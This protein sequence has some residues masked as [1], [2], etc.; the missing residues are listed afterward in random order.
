MIARVLGC[1]VLAWGLV[2]ARA[3]ASALPAT[4]AAPPPFPLVTATLF[5]SEF[6]APGVVRGDYRLLTSSGPLHVTVVAADLHDPA[7]RLDAVTADDRMISPGETI[8]SMAAR[9]GAVAGINADYFD[10][11]QT[12]QPTNIVV[13]GGALLHPPNGRAAVS[14]MNDGSVRF[15][16][17]VAV[18]GGLTDPQLAGVATALGGGPLL[19]A[20]GQ[21]A[22]DPNA[23]APEEAGLRFPVAGIASETDGTLLLIAVDG[24]LPRFSIGLTRAELGALMLALGASDGMATDS[25]GSATLV[26]RI[27]GERVPRVLNTPSDGK[28]RPVADGLFIYSSAPNGPAAHLIYRPSAIRALGGVTIRLQGAFT[29][30]A[31]HPLPD[32]AP[33]WTLTTPLQ[34]GDT[35]AENDAGGLV[36]RVPVQV[37]SQL[38]ALD[39]EPARPNPEPGAPIAFSATGSVRGLIPVTLGDRVRWSASTGTID[40]SGNFRA[41]AHDAIVT[42]SAGGVTASVGVR[43]GRHPVEVPLFAGAAAERWRFVTIPA[44]GPGALTPE[45]DCRCLRL[46]YDFTAT[47]R[48]AY[49]AQDV[50]LP[51][52]AVGF[53]FDVFGDARGAGLRAT[54]V[55]RDGRTF[56]V[57]LA[58]RVDWSG[59]RRIDARIPAEAIPPVRLVSIYAVGTLGDAPVHAA[60]ALAFRDASLLIAGTP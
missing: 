34:P 40:A 53:A 19:I 47:E 7:V 57:T 24:R 42:A 27:L 52:A 6:V 18:P 37:V 43:V 45:P 46:R 39:V 54:L 36:A 16:R 13:R 4:I 41:G 59:W 21:P 26:A 20:N 28:E 2:A 9:T 48:A 44:A 3:Q 1:A 51:E 17:Y 55:D 15:G 11:G 25:G 35:V 60:G 23:P 31:G 10:I 49:A 56:R 22:V 5:E 58:R 33:P 30:A 50:A 14:V 12:N 8:S 38:D 32:P 29:D